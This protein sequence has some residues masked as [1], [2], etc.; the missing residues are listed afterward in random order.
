MPVEQVREHAEGRIWSG[1]QGKERGLVD[2]FGGLSTALAMARKLAKLGA[3]APVSV[4]GAK[5]GLLEML[6]LGGDASEAELRA[7]LARY[8]ASHAWLAALPPDV[9]AHVTALG[10]L[11][12]GEHVVAALP[13]ALELR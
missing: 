13:F 1:E 7:A 6:T 8:Q 2:E 12:R 3:D 9:R 4:E 10:P 5:E 11:A